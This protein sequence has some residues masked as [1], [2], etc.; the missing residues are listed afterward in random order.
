MFRLHDAHA[1]DHECHVFK[2]SSCHHL[3]PQFV[4]VI[5][6]SYSISSIIISH[7]LNIFFYSGASFSS[8]DDPGAESVTLL[9]L[10]FSF[11][12][13][14]QPSDQLD[15]THIDLFTV[16]VR[17][18]SRC[19]HLITTI[20]SIVFNRCYRVY[21]IPLSSLPAAHPMIVKLLWQD[22]RPGVSELFPGTSALKRIINRDG[23]GTF[24]I[25]HGAEL[26]QPSYIN[27]STHDKV[28]SHHH[29]IYSLFVAKDF[30]NVFI[31]Y[32]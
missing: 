6:L 19:C 24:T 28:C 5:L 30:I 7:V 1:L 23:E 32:S 18:F 2:K 25:V 11:E 13:L 27:L 8:V 3:F 16:R 9:L 10:P 31:Y 21:F 20:I 17:R 22:V 4:S 12:M 26:G 15:P 14:Y 29:L